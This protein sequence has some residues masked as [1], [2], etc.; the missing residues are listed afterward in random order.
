M[1][2][3]VT[4]STETVWHVGQWRPTV[5]SLPVTEIQVDGHELEWVRKNVT[6]LGVPTGSPQV[7]TWR[8]AD[9]RK[10]YDNIKCGRCHTVLDHNEDFCAGSWDLPGS[11]RLNVD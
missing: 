11:P 10:I 6:G 3:I 8:G 5:P 2:Y 4:N 9:A 7:Q 1:M